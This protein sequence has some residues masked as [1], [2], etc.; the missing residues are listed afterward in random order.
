[1][2]YLNEH[3]LLEIG[4]D[5]E[6][7]IAAIEQAVHCIDK[8]DYAQ[9]IKPYL[10]FKDLK[11]RIIAMP[12]YV[13]GDI[14][15]CGI[16]W[17][18]SFPDNIYKEKPRAHSVVVLNDTSTGEPVSII[19][20]SLLSVIRTAA[21]SGLMMKYYLKERKSAKYKLGIIGWGPI[22]QYH[23]RMS[24][25]VLGDRASEIWLYDIRQ[26]IHLEDVPEAYRDKVKIAESWKEAYG[27]SDIL[28]TCTVASESYIDMKPKVGAL[29]LNVS[30]RDFKTDVYEYVSH[31][32]IVDDWEEVCRENTDIEN[33]SKYKGLRQE[34]T[35]SITD[36]ICRNGMAEYRMNDTVMFNPMGMAIFDMAIAS[37]YLDCAV[38]NGIGLLLE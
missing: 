6:H 7:A 28:I 31:S 25:A 22:G 19:N 9:P 12:A 18:A 33:F 1:M 16:K 27:Q 34:D 17:I 32:I 2:I 35:R 36:I 29:L 20:T 4:V 15:L 21:V 23:L 26:I 5:W 11:N 37:Y 8:E 30:L 38:K 10:R 13:G 14:D 3:D 24:L